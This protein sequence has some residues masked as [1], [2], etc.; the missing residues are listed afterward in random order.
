MLMLN[1]SCIRNFS[2]CIIDNCISLIVLTLKNFCLKSYRTILQSSQLI[3]KILIDHSCENHLLCNLRVLF[4]K[5]KE[6]HP[7]TNFRSFQHL[8]NNCCIPADWDSLIS[9]IKVV[10]IINKPK[11]Q[12]LNN[13]C[14]KFCTLSSPLF[15]RITFDQSLI[16]ISTPKE[17]CLLLQILRLSDSCL[18][19][20]F[21]NDIL[22]F[23]RCTDIPHLA[24]C[25]H[26]KR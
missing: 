6:I 17:K 13:K 24:E 1:N 3:T 25:I 7:C 15:L 8:L 26:I 4:S 2:L 12:T 5:L 18:F 21:L 11:W 22:R 9:I 23:L 19:T 20:L 14:R 10:I 16:N